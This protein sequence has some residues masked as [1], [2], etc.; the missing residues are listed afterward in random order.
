MMEEA[1]AR[2]LIHRLSLGEAELQWP[3]MLPA[4]RFAQLYPNTGNWLRIAERISSSVGVRLSREG[5]GGSL[6]RNL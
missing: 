5:M 4:L 6:A 1:G 2:L 3:S